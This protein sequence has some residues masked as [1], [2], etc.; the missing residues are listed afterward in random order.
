[1]TIA[2]TLP[3]TPMTAPAPDRR[4]APRRQPAIGTVCRLDTD[5]GPPA[6]ALI[7]N[8]STTGISMLVSEPRPSGAVLSGVLETMTGAHALTISVR[9]VHL[10]QLGTGDYY[11]GAV[12]SRPLSE[13]ELKP[14]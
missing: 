3:P 2:T 8:I 6:L 14:F 11:V 12:F 5:G 1:M 9:V 7:W 4:V 10:R 13:D